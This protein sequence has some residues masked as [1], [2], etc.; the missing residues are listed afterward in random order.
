MDH[1][2]LTLRQQRR[3]RGWLVLV[4]ISVRLCCR[5][6]VPH[7]QAKATRGLS[8]ATISAELALRPRAQCDN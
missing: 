1:S 8:L 3:V 6:L 5:R 4:D 2:L 7:M